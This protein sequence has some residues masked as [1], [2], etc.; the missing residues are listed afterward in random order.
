MHEGELVSAWAKARIGPKQS[1]GQTQIVI[2]SKSLRYRTINGHIEEA[3]AWANVTI[4][5]TELVGH[6]M[7]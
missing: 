2:C 6:C 7:V 3:E 5:P 4:V 1:L